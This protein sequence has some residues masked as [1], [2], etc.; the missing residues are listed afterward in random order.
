MATH[1]PALVTLLTVALMIWTMIGV[2]NARR[3]TGIRAPATTGHPDFERAFR[4]QMNT[5]EAVAAFLPCLWLASAYGFPMLAG[6]LGGA[7][8]VGR[9]WYAIGYTQSADKRSMGFM[10][11]SL[12]NLALL[13]IALWGIV[14]AMMAA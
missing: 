13:G 8:I 3:R 14:R 6:V 7:W 2:G 10:I 9:V 11:G 4:V 12:A 5:I 1:L